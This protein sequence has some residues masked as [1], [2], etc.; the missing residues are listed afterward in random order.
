V[1]GISKP[2]RAGAGM[3]LA[4]TL[5]C[6]GEPLDDL[7]A[8]CALRVSTLKG[9]YHLAEGVHLLRAIRNGWPLDRAASSSCANSPPAYASYDVVGG[10]L[11][12]ISSQFC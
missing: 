5:P 11:V 8:W 6:L 4:Q 2:H 7:A 10:R 9:T 1:S 3:Q 12:F